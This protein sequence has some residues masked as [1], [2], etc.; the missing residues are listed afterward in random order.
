MPY[1]DLIRIAAND[2]ELSERAPAYLIDN[3][4]ESQ[5]WPESEEVFNQLKAKGYLLGVVSNCSRELGRRAIAQCETSF[6]AFITAEDVGFYK[7]HPKTYRDILL[8]LNVKPDE[9]IL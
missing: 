3:W 9:A 8:A 6:D 2:V 7:P 1:E 4:D 5:P